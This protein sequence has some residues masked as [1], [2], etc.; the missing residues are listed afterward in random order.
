[1]VILSVVIGVL[2]MMMITVNAKLWWN[3]FVGDEHGQS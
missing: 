3:F 2:Y 1:M